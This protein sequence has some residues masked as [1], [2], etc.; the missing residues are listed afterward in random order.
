VPARRLARSQVALDAGWRATRTER[1]AGV[2][3]HTR[4]ECAE[5]EAAHFD[6]DALLQQEDEQ[7]RPAVV[8]P[9]QLEGRSSGLRL[10]SHRGN[11]I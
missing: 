11:H 9:A 1:A 5:P 10:R 2:N 7:V 8:P 4:D 3:V 6:V